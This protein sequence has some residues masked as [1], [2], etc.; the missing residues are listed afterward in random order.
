M[1]ESLTTLHFLNIFDDKF[2]CAR[3][4]AISNLSLRCRTSRRGGW[5][6]GGKRKEEEGWQKDA[7]IA[8]VFMS[9]TVFFLSTAFSCSFLYSR[10]CVEGMRSIRAVLVGILG[11][12]VCL[13]QHIF[14]CENILTTF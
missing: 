4:R 10:A 12:D 6:G 7:R 9:V 5:E 13:I 11:N 3:S 1:G 14:F 2:F 8:T